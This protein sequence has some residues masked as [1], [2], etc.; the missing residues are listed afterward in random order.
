MRITLARN[1]APSLHKGGG[2]EFS[3]AVGAILSNQQRVVH[4]RKRNRQVLLASPYT[5]EGNGANNDLTDN[6]ATNSVVFQRVLQE[7]Q[8]IKSQDGR[9]RSGRVHMSICRLGRVSPNS[10]GAAPSSGR[11][12][13][14]S[15]NHFLEALSWQVFRCHPDQ[16]NPY[17]CHWPLHRNVVATQVGPCSRPRQR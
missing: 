11:I 1:W 14:A 17:Q 10:K 4:S 16:D 8:S 13:D 15:S 9:R 6:G 3:S 7:R 12:Q 2:G 5:G